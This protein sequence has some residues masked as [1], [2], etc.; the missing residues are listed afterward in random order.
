MKLAISQWAHSDGSIEKTPTTVE[1]LDWCMRDLREVLL[2]ESDWTV[3]I[4]SPLSQSVKDEW[5]AWR[6]WM[7][8]ITQHI[9]ITDFVEYVDIL[10]PP[11]TGRPKS[12]VN[13]ESV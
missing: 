5:I 10:S 3:G 7:R 13:V 11:T 1:E 12:W 8:D 4:D 9:T 6:Q 2:K